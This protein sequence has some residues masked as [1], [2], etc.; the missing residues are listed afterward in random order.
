VIVIYFVYVYV[1]TYI[2]IYTYIHK[3][4]YIGSKI[5]QT[6]KKWTPSSSSGEGSQGSVNRMRTVSIDKATPIQE[7]IR[8]SLTP[9]NIP[10]MAKS[11]LK[12]TILDDILKNTEISPKPL[13][14]S[15]GD[16]Y[17]D[18]DNSPYRKG[19]TPTDMR[20]VDDG[21]YVFNTCIYVY[22]IY[23]YIYLEYIYLYIDIRS[24]YII[25]AEISQQ[26]LLEFKLKV[27]PLKIKLFELCKSTD[28]TIGEV[29]N[30]NDDVSNSNEDDAD[31]ASVPSIAHTVVELDP[32]LPSNGID[33]FMS[34]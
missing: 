24:F 19:G 22:V 23:V 12:T 31:M 1:Y 34:F 21:K 5:P 28:G 26:S 18:D 3:Y 32:K 11:T 33:N 25:D 17:E 16:E 29:Y 2:Y 6:V 27:S 13:L 14:Q 8:R 7:S 20:S 30:V 9:T 4:I 10:M 15:D